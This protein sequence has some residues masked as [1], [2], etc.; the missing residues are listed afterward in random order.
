MTNTY[1]VLGQSNPTANVLTTLYI[2]PAATS[3]TVSSITVCNQAG[4]FANFSVSVA[5]AGAADNAKQYVY[6]QLVIDGN[7]T[8]IATVGFTLAATA[9]VRVEASSSNISFCLFGVQ[10]T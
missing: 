2:T 5:V 1:Q 3:T 6:Y 10:V 4:T 9:V 7:D 8:F